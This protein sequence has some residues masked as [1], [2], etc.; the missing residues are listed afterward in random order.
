MS[1]P[2]G[3][4]RCGTMTAPCLPYCMSPSPGGPTS[5]PKP[6]RYSG[7][8]IR[9]MPGPATCSNRFIRGTSPVSLTWCGRRGAPPSRRSA[10]R[11]RNCGPSSGGAAG[12][13]WWRSR[14]AT[15]CT[16]CTWNSPSW[17]RSRPTRTSCFIRWWGRPSPAT[18]TTPPGSG[19]IRR[20][21]RTTRRAGCCCRCCRWPCGWP[22]PGRRCGTRSSAGTTA[23]RISSWAAITPAQVP[24]PPGARSTSRMPPRNCSSST[25]GRSG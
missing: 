24:M 18:S 7:P 9:P 16:G 25:P 5:P 22:G 14:P 20:S 19:V 6:K 1:R 10:T 2:G 21:C 12:R 15:R 8:P 4:W 13:G 17:H 23:R 3:V 11:P